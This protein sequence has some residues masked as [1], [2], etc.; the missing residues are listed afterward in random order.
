MHSPLIVGKRP[1]P[2]ATG[3]TALQS[4]VVLLLWAALTTGSVE[5]Q[6]SSCRAAADTAG[7]FVASLQGSYDGMDTVWMKSQGLPYATPDAIKLVTQSSTCKAAVA[8]Y[9]QATGITPPLA[10]V[11]VA[12]LGKKGYVV[13]NPKEHAG[14][15]QAMWVFDTQWTMKRH[16]FH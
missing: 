8:A 7:P 10:S 6:G 16:I 12:A 4:C 15:Y 9:N 5:A 11:Y 3:W 14:D 2:P 1:M 13:M